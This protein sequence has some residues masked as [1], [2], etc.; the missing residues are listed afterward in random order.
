MQQNHFGRYVGSESSSGVSFPDTVKVA[1]AYGIK[2]DRIRT[3]QELYQKINTILAEPGPFVCE[4]A[5]P[6]NQPLIPRV[7]S[8]KKPDGT[9]ISRPLEDLYPF[10]PRKEFLNNMVIKPI[11]PLKQV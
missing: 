3:Q 1:N 9:I 4:I 5:M 10:L 7:S 6:E 8:V 11:E 2:A